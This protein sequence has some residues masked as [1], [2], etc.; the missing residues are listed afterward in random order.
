M[1]GVAP[2]SGC[3]LAASAAVGVAPSLTASRAPDAGAHGSGLLG[4][5]VAAAPRAFA[6]ATVPASTLAHRPA[7]VAAGPQGARAPGQLRSPGL[8]PSPAHTAHAADRT[9]LALARG[10]TSTPALAVAPRVGLFES[11]GTQPAA[12][13]ALIGEGT[14]RPVDLPTAASSSAPPQPSGGDD[15]AEDRPLQPCLLARWVE[16][17]GRVWFDE[18]S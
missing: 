5:T 7:G 15:V 17:P 8:A 14:A 10:P 18:R 13:S 4:V 12:V 6:L 11:G 2:A 3:H 9:A 16:G 1:P